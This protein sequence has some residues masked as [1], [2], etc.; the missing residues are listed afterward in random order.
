LSGRPVGGC[1]GC[2]VFVRARGGAVGAV[3]LLAAAA[4]AAP[5]CVRGGVQL[6]GSA[7]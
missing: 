3:G 2:R 1:R 7:C 5:C 4:V 6:G